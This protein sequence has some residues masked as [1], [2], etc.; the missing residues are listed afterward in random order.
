MAGN[1]KRGIICVRDIGAS[2][3]NHC[4]RGKAISITYSECVFIA[5]V[6]QHAKRMRRTKLSSVDCL[7][8][9]YFYTL[10][11]TRHDF[12]GGGDLLNIKCVFA[13]ILHLLQGDQKVCVHLMITIQ[14]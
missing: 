6:I 9:P 1:N 5:I 8:L 11:H 12:R 2:S 4:C 14:K 10:S 3:L 7:A 13:F